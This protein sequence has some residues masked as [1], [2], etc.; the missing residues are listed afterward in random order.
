VTPSPHLEG[1]VISAL[2]AAC[3]LTP[4]RVRLETNLMDLGIDSVAMLAVVTKVEASLGIELSPHDILGLFSA[5]RV[6][7]LIS[8]FLGHSTVP[9][10]GVK[11]I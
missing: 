9:S 11:D 6:A 7:D 3:K 2:S 10:P 8:L 4:D 5:S 1:L